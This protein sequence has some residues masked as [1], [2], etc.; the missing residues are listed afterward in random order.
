MRQKA[1]YSAIKTTQ[2]VASTIT[3]SICILYHALT[4]G[5]VATILV[6]DSLQQADFLNWERKVADKKKSSSAKV[7]TR[8]VASTSETKKPKTS[9]K[10]SVSQA[11]K[12]IKKSPKVDKTKKT[13]EKKVR[14][15]YF[16]G[17]W[18]ELKQVRWP[19]RKSTWSLTLGVIAYS[20]FFA[21]LIIVLDAFFKYLFDLLVKG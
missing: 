7:T 4:S 20:I 3:S 16:V 10:K 12:T 2:P 17:A 15:N 9:A 6:L 5:R 21:V 8:V 18:R 11:D 1:M 19:D 13:K 14:D